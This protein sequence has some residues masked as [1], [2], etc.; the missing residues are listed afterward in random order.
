MFHHTTPSSRSVS[1]PSIPKP[2]FLF[3]VF[4]YVLCFE[5]TFLGEL[6]HTHLLAL[7][8]EPTA[9]K[10]MDSVKVQL[11]GP[12]SFLGVTEKNMGERS[13]LGA[14]MTRSQ[15]HHRS[16]PQHRGKLANAGALIQGSQP[17]HSSSRLERL[18]QCLG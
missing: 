8:G 1:F 17:A 2:A 16:P 5:K 15:P 10:S 9:D 3:S 13:L 4:S 11:G 12:M 7:E 6:Q 14:E 18:L